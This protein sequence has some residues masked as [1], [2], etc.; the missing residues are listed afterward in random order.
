MSALDLHADDLLSAAQN[1]V[2]APPA[3]PERKWSAWGTAKAVGSAVPA[4]AADALAAGSEVGYGVYQSWIRFRDASPAERKQQDAGGVIRPEDFTNDF[5]DSL[6]DRGKEFAPDPLTAHTADLLAFEATRMIGK[7]VGYTVGIGPAG[8]FVAAADEALRASDELR[9][10]GV[11][12]ETRSKA[13]MVAGAGTAAAALPLVGATKLGTAALYAAGG[14]GGFIAQ[15]AATREILKSAGYDKL[16]QQYDPFDPVGLA[17]SSLLPLPFVA[18]G[19][20]AASK[21]K[22]SPEAVDAAHVQLLAEQRRATS[23]AEPTDLKGQAADTA[24][25][26]T[27]A[28]QIADGEKVNVAHLA[29]EPA[30]VP[31]DRD[32]NFR[33]WFGDSKVVDEQGA[34]LVMYHGTRSDFGEFDAAKVGA[35]FDESRGFYLT[36]S[37]DSASIYA[38]GLANASIGWRPGSKFAK[39]V[40]DGA[41][42]MQAFVSLKNPKV[43]ETRGALESVVDADP[44]IIDAA[45]AAGHDGV[46]VRRAVGDEYDGTLAI[47]FK[48]EQVKSAIGNSGKFDP[49]SPSLTDHPIVEW[50]ARVEHAIK[51]I[52]AEAEAAQKAIQPSPQDGQSKPL[53]VIE[54]QRAAQADASGA[55]PA[56]GGD[57]ARADAAERNVEAPGAGAAAEASTTQARLDAIANEFPDLEVMLDGMDKPMK[58]ADFLDAVKAEAD[59]MKADS[60]LYQLAAECALLNGA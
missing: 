17:V 25:R 50:G 7:L 55:K 2:V 56:A 10:K 32:A 16:S 54:N 24:A 49:N 36:S 31:I 1:R 39:P 11:D 30:P 60:P 13:G 41:N 40:E 21:A 58:L 29:P 35:R 4:I 45:K 34:P 53:P 5:A 42:V 14:P 23:L 59:E 12:L 9:L 15:Q 18:M 27:A 19:M 20:R 44:G 46:I 8:P 22:V 33:A 38:D 28:R 47:A 43:I 26:D 37:P 3:P 52:R 57:E 6:R 48:P 51:A